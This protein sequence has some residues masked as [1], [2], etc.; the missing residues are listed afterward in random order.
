VS[1]LAPKANKIRHFEFQNFGL[2]KFGELISEFRI[3]EIL[4]LK[5]ESRISDWRNSEIKREFQNFGLAE[6][7]WVNFRISDWRNSEITAAFRISDWRNSG[8]SLESLHLGPLTWMLQ[9]LSILV[10]CMGLEALRISHFR[11]FKNP[12]AVF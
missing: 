8:P 5:G 1:T 2:A 10:E 11:Q 9:G 7:R 4:K 3:G 6:F 12:H